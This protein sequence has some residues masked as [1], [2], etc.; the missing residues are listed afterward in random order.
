VEGYCHLIQ[1]QGGVPLSFAGWELPEGLR[2]ALWA[3]ESTL[4]AGDREKQ[5]NS[6]G[7]QRCVVRAYWCAVYRACVCVFRAQIDVLVTAVQYARIT[8]PEC[9]T[10]AGRRRTQMGCWNVM[11]P[12]LVSGEIGRLGRPAWRDAQ[13]PSVGVRRV[14]Q[15]GAAYLIFRNSDVIEQLCVNYKQLERPQSRPHWYPSP[16]PSSPCVQCKHAHLH[17]SASAPGW[18][19]PTTPTSTTPVTG[20]P[21]SPSVSPAS[22]PRPPPTLLASQTLVV[23]II[24]LILHDSTDAV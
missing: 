10:R 7:L 23:L 3:V 2:A 11:V 19:T 8:L 12:S 9:A 6:C 17:R 16:R 14:F 5:V 22:Q 21:A 1:S 13:T 18:M 15:K 20:Q 4:R 24:V